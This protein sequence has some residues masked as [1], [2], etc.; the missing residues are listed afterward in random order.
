MW[1]V[2][3]EAICFFVPVLW[4][5]ER[6]KKSKNDSRE[7]DVN[8]K[9]QHNCRSCRTIPDKNLILSRYMKNVFHFRKSLMLIKFP[10]EG[11]K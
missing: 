3:L 5:K 8:W 2:H 7:N 10:T 6:I 11:N 1:V 4:I 9:N